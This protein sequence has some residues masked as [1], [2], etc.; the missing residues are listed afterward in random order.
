MPLCTAT[1]DNVTFASLAPDIPPSVAITSPSSGASFTAPAT[2]PITATASDTDGTVVSVDFYSGSTLIGSS[3]TAPYSFAVGPAFRAG[4]YSLT[5][6]ATD[7][8][9]AKTTSAAV[10]IGVSGGLGSLD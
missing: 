3:S 4:A 10:S 1:F 9:G 6:V 5:A 2:I 8:R 7:D